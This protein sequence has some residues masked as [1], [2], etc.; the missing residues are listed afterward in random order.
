MRKR[1][2]LLLLVAVLGVGG[3]AMSAYATPMRVAQ[4]DTTSSDEGDDDTDYG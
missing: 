4:E 3:T 2:S 1:L